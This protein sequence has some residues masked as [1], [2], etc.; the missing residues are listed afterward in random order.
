M[1]QLKI[2]GIA[3][4][5]IISIFLV[6]IIILAVGYTFNSYESDTARAI[7]QS[8]REITVTIYDD[9]QEGIVWE[10]PSALS[11]HFNIRLYSEA[12]DVSFSV[13]IDN[14][15]F[16]EENLQTAYMFPILISS[17]DNQQDKQQPFAKAEVYFRHVDNGDVVYYVTAS[18][19]EGTNKE[20]V[21]D[22]RLHWEIEERYQEHIDNTKLSDELF[23]IVYGEVIN[24]AISQWSKVNI[25]DLYIS[26]EN[27]PA[28]LT[29]PQA[30]SFTDR[31]RF[32][33]VDV[34]SS[35]EHNVFVEHIDLTPATMLEVL[36]DYRLWKAELPLYSMEGKPMLTEHWGVLSENLASFEAVQESAPV[37][38]E[39]LQVAAQDVRIA[40]LDRFRKK[41]HDG[42][43][44]EVPNSYTPYEP[45][46]FW[47]VPAEHIGQRFIRSIREQENAG[48]HVVGSYLETLAI[49]SMNHSLKQQTE[50]GYWLTEPQSNWLHGDYGIEAGFYDTRF[51]TDA[52]MFLLDIFNYYRIDR[53]ERSSSIELVELMEVFDAVTEYADFMLWFAEEYSFTTEN[54][55]L[56]VQDYFHPTATHEPTHVSLNHLVTEM[57]FLLQYY[58][59][60]FEL[61]HNQSFDSLYTDRGNIYVDTAMRIRLAIHDTEMDWVKDNYDLW[62]AYMPDGSYGLQDYPRL[63]RN[64]L[65]V[66]VELVNKVLNEDDNVFRKLIYY[67]E[68]YLQENGIPLW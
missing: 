64:D 19:L 68:K 60:L 37:I 47:L 36:G 49:V 13:D 43:Y 18:Y 17:I 35:L 24:N 52:A 5:L 39:Q 12:A 2:D 6:T 27:Y 29:L 20:E 7:D 44:Y 4:S 51:S 56:L 38:D 61:E 42:I 58:M 26:E 66:G 21:A 50:G 8:G 57:N 11:E 65:R 30:A 1:R 28:T 32:G 14:V 67:K 34:F 46:S 63:T 22:Y 62:Y 55:G 45:R 10:L 15:V 31:L 3:L 59:A 53:P 48:D 16:S 23:Y 33:M 54:G 40:D 9:A 41:R 25:S